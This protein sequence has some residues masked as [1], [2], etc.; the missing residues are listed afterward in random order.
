MNLTKNSF[1]INHITSIAIFLLFLTSSVYAQSSDSEQVIYPS[2]SLFGFVQQQY[3]DDR[4]P[5]TPA[6]FSIHRAR[7]GVT[8]SITDNL[9]VRILGGFVE[10][11]Q[12]NPQLLHAHMDY[13]INPL[14]TIRAGQF[15]LPFGIEGFEGIPLNPAIER[16]IAVRRLNTFRMFSDIGVQVSGNLSRINYAVALVNG[17]GANQAEQMNLK[18]VIGRVGIELADNFEIGLSGHAGNYQPAQDPDNDQARYRAGIDM[19]YSGDPLFFRGEFITRNDHQPDSETI[20]MN[21][22]YILGGLAITD[23]LEGVTR[24]EYFTPNTDAND[25]RYVGYTV[26]ANY[27]FVGRTRLSVNYEFRDDE[28]NRDNGNMLTVQMQIVL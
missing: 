2:Y 11:P 12:N 10:P 9:R 7:L 3:V 19:E 16:S 8:G 20:T 4:T 13:R 18:D 5:N 6:G 28:M 26:G 25:N 24:F 15:L 21:G 1:E 27:Y 14:L 22:G 17:T 23:R